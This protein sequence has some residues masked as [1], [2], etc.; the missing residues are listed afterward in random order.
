MNAPPSVPPPC[1]G[2]R[3]P[4]APS[5]DLLT[6]FMRQS[7]ARQEDIH[8]WCNNM[9]QGQVSLQDNTYNLSLGLPDFPDDTL[10]TR[11][12]FAAHIPLIKG[13]P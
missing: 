9:R 4:K 2:T 1:R 11:A 7:L 8:N 3:V 13:E 5:T 6:D 12:Q 10:M